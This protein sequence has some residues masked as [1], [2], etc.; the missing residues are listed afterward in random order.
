MVS[1]GI[2]CSRMR[3]PKRSCS[4]IFTFV[5]GQVSKCVPSLVE[6]IPVLLQEWP[7]GV[8][9]TLSGIRCINADAG[10]STP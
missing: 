3:V 5:V 1:V 8:Y 9:Q 7:T 10:D 6:R 4:G 2:S